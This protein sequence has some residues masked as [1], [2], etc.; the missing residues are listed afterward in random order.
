[1]PAAL[2]ILAL[3]ILLSV[4][5]RAQDPLL[6]QGQS[7]IQEDTQELSIKTF[8][9]SEPEKPRPV[10]L[11]FP[12]HKSLL[13]PGYVGFEWKFDNQPKK[14]DQPTTEIILEN[15]D[16]NK[17]LTFKSKGSKRRVFCGPGQYRWRVEV[18]PV[19]NIASKSKPKTKTKSSVKLQPLKSRWRTFKIVTFKSRD[20]A[21]ERANS[22]VVK[23][24]VL[25]GKGPQAVPKLGEESASPEF[26][27]D[28]EIPFK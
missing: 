8:N 6:Y 17:K 20:P 19:R 18:T 26:E 22:K 11:V 7:E 23:P 13:T 3:I 12:P 9:T 16:T 27:Q 5:V 4:Q 21:A 28:P 1:L 25:Q 14:K 15:I 24:L 2:Y 10:Q